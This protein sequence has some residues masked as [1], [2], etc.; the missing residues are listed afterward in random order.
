MGDDDTP[1]GKRGRA[2]GK[3]DAKGEKKNPGEN[4]D[5]R[6]KRI[7]LGTSAIVSMTKQISIFMNFKEMYAENFSPDCDTEEVL[8]F[9]AMIEYLMTNL[10]VFLKKNGLHDA[11]R[12]FFFVF[13]VIYVIIL[14]NLLEPFTLMYTP[15]ELLCDFLFM[16]P[17]MFKTDFNKFRYISNQ[18]TY[19]TYFEYL[20]SN[21]FAL[22]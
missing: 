12:V 8:C 4:T 21:F 6:K 2:S 20:G 19:A 1:K 5:S 3:N 13:L 10:E 9:R 14:P 22:K 16:K 11:N 7:L 15:D 18:G 17:E